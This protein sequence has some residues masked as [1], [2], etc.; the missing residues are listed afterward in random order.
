[1]TF[2]EYK[3]LERLGD[4]VLRLCLIEI[5]FFDGAKK[6]HSTN[7]TIARMQTNAFMEVVSKKMGIIPHPQDNS[8]KKYANAL[9]ARI[10]EV[11][12]LYGIEKAKELV[13]NYNGIFFNEFD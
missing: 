5:F 8:K 10:G 3:D 2:Q 1:M 11:Y 13:R 6:K 4:A 9:E 12:K 7:W